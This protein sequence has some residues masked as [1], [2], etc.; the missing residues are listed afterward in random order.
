MSSVFNFIVPLLIGSFIFSILG[1]ILHF[2]FW[3]W[4]KYDDEINEAFEFIGALGGC[5]LIF[6]TICITFYVVGNIVLN[7]FGGFHVG[8]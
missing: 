1:I 5:I 6:S 7:Y 4:K 3:F 2:I 8:M